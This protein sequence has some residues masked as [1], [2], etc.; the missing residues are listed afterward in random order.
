MNKVVEILIA[1]VMLGIVI[2]FHEFGHFI[3]AKINGV[4]VKEFSIGLGPRI[5]S[6]E[7]KGTKYSLKLLPLGGS[8]QMLG[9]GEV[10]DEEGSFN[11]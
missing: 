1:L 10:S 3:M 5:L 2:A 7:Y 9:E 8:C 4:V 6:K 11:S